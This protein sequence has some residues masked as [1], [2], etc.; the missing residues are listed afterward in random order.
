MGGLWQS[1]DTVGSH[2]TTS[3]AVGAG[4]PRRSLHSEAE[5]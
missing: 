1:V 3:K 4:K 2:S 5:I